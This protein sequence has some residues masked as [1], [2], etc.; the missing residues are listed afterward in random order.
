MLSQTFQLTWQIYTSIWYWYNRMQ[1]WSSNFPIKH[2][3]WKL[4]ATLATKRSWA[5]VA[6]LQLEKKVTA[7]HHHMANEKRLA[8]TADSLDLFLF[9]W[10]GV[11]RGGGILPQIYKHPSQR[12]E[13][14][15]LVILTRTDPGGDL[16]QS[17]EK[18]LLLPPGICRQR[19]REGLRH[20][21]SQ[22]LVFQDFTA[23]A[24]F[25]LYTLFIRPGRYKREIPISSA[26][27]A[28]DGD[29]YSQLGA[30][31]HPA[32]PPLCSVCVWNTPLWGRGGGFLYRLCQVPREEAARKE[33]G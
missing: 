4:E 29:Y 17:H 28:S 30:S 33:E 3:K 24:F 7:R 23:Q 6:H 21:T 22:H 5:L 27:E 32:P 20:F 16:M 18:N 14:E 2:F 25:R 12:E 15:A 19:E 8:H 10:G 26:G 9:L 1:K 11:S 13:E 31:N